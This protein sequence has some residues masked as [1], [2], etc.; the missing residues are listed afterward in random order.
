MQLIPAI[1]WDGITLVQIQM[2]RATV[3]SPVG[4]S[5]S[6]E[7]ISVRNAIGPKYASAFSLLLA[8]CQ[9]ESS[10]IMLS[11]LTTRTRWSKCSLPDGLMLIR[12]SL[13]AASHKHLHRAAFHFELA[14]ALTRHS[15]PSTVLRYH[16]A[17]QR[18]IILF[19]Y[20]RTLRKVFQRWMWA[21]VGILLISD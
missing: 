21:T 20:I 16:Y 10:A 6:E 2:I 19:W 7:C 8:D 5:E 11:T 18:C 3:T 1:T 15:H 17:L 13:V 14:F 4:V 9:A 12:V